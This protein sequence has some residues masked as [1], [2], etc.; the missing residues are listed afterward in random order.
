MNGE[1][2]KKFYEYNLWANTTLLEL[3]TTLSDEQ[4]KAKVGGVVGT[5]R[6]TIVHLVRAEGFYIRYLSGSF[7]EVKVG[8]EMEAWMQLSMQELLEIAKMTGGR[9]IEL[10]VSADLATRHDREFEGNPFHF[11]NWAVILQAI[12][13]GIEHRT[14]IKAILTELGI[15]HP[16][17]ASWDYSAT[18]LGYPTDI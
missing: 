5:L 18:L 10:S 6:E 16:E 13:H 4:L 12:Y 3:L 2:T 9:L 17:M 11:H 1:M 14:Q 15:K 7:P 8:E